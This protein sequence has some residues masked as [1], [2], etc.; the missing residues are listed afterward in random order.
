M[1]IIDTTIWSKVYWRRK[2]VDRDKDVIKKVLTILDCE[3]E[4]LLGPVRQELL[5]GI[6][7]K[8]T[9]YDL[10]IKLY[11]FNNYEIQLADHDLAAEYCNIC[12]SKGIQ[13][14]QTDYLICAVA[15]RYNFGI[16]TE[17]KDFTFY[18]K[19]LPI[20]LV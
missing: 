3:K 9:F 8:D 16:F 1:I 7:C 12:H 10:K 11:G 19:Y 6:T 4:V 13:G 17:D 2:I 14:S 18:K 15:Y 5:S 20:K